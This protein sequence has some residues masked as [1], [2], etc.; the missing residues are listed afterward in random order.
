MAVSS[1]A[2]SHVDPKASLGGLAPNSHHSTTVKSELSAHWRIQEP[3][4]RR[5]T[6]PTTAGEGHTY[7][8]RDYHIKQENDS[9]E[10]EDSH[11]KHED[12]S[13]WQ[14]G[15]GIEET[16]VKK[17]QVPEN[18]DV[19]RRGSAVMEVYSRRW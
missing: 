12:H 11:V 3:K 5:S 16:T 6:S 1:P 10:W 19:R 17:E 4:E 2:P 8:Q 7:R 9:S 18:A 14:S 13:R 15:G